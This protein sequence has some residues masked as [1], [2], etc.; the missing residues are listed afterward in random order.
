MKRGTY[1]TDW[2]S[3]AIMPLTTGEKAL[4]ANA[5]RQY[6]KE[7]KQKM[8]TRQFRKK[9]LVDGAMRIFVEEQTDGEG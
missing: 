3:V 7:N 4:I 2:E 6:N 5:R 1:G 9:L 8:N